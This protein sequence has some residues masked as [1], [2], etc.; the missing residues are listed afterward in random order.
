MIALSILIAALAVSTFASSSSS[1]SSTSST[2]NNE[3]R[4][5]EIAKNIKNFEA[6]LNTAVSKALV[7]GALSGTD[8]Q[9][10]LK[11]YGIK[12]DKSFDKTFELLN[13]VADG[14]RRKRNNAHD[15]SSSSSSSSSSNDVVEI[16]NSVNDFLE[17]LSQKD[18]DL[19]RISVLKQALAQH[20]QAGR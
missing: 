17:E 14:A 2:D 4:K 16:E 11:T 1:S 18:K 19:F 9:K 13:A 15:S 6:R 12:S 3:H 10:F 7:E 8:I 20:L 5:A